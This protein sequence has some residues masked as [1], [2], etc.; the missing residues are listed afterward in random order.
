MISIRSMSSQR[1]LCL[2]QHLFG[3]VD[4]A[5][6]HQCRL[7]ADIG[8]GLDLHAR[9]ERRGASSLAAADQHRGGAVDDAGRI[10]GVVDVVDCLDLRMRLD[11][12]GIEAAHLAHLHERGLQLRERLHRRARAQ[13]LI[14][15][16]DRQSVHVF[17]LDHRTGEPALVPS[18]RGALLAFDRIGVNRIAREAVF[19]RDQ[20]GRYALRHEVRL[21]RDRRIDRPGAARR[22]DP[23]AAHRIRR[24]RLWSS[25]ADRT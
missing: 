2:L 17:D 19:G 11:G 7:G 12:N 4:R 21:E 1:H 14:L 3:D 10:A 6:Q 24:R 15:G 22:A 9:L 23:D 13:V 20:I 5:S 25:H 16:E 8:E 18:R